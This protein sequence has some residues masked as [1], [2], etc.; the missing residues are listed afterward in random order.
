MNI[1]FREEQIEILKYEKGIMSISAVPGSGKTFILTHLAAKLIK[2]NIKEGEK[3]LLLTYMNSAVEN[4]ESRL[5]ELIDIDML[6]KIQISTI[7]KLAAD[8]LKE[9]I[10][11][12]K[13]AENY[14]LVDIYD[15]DRI[16][17]KH[18]RVW[19]NLEKNKFKFLFKDKEFNERNT[20]DFYNVLKKSI[21]FNISKLKMEGITYHKIFTETDKYDNSLLPILSKIYKEYQ[22]E[23]NKKSAIDYD[24]L[25]FYTYDLL[26]NNK[27]I[28]DIYIKRYK[29]IFEDEAQDSNGLQNKIIALLSGKLGNIVKV[30]DSNQSIMG[31][32]TS[33]SPDIFRKFVK[34]APIKKEVSLSARNTIDIQKLANL[35]HKYTKE[36]HPCIEARGALVKPYIFPVEEGLYKNP[37]ADG[38]SIKQITL[39]DEFEETKYLIYFIKKFR[40]KYPEKSIGILLPRNSLISTISAKLKKE[41]IEFDTISDIDLEVMEALKKLGDIISFLAE[42]YNNKE[43]INIIK[44]YFL[45][46]DE[47]INK[48]IIRALE[49]IWLEKL[50]FTDYDFEEKVKNSSQFVYIKKAINKLSMLLE[51]SINSP[52]RI[53]VYIGEN[54]G[55]SVEDQSLIDAIALNLKKVFKLNPKWTLKDLAIE[56]K[57]SQNN[58]FS[59]FNPIIRDKKEKEKNIVITNYH[60]SKGREWD[61]V[62]LYGLNTFYFPVFL[63]QAAYGDK[64]YLHEKHLNPEAYMSWEIDNYLGKA[65]DFDPILKY[66]SDRVAECIRLIFVGITRAK[67]HIL[68][69]H[70]RE[71]DDF[72]S[73]LFKKIIERIYNG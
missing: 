49:N 23:L 67:E 38:R 55:F 9:N 57:K 30:G 16:I 32:F 4:F 53:L 28:C 70:N 12:T 29:Y 66:K 52:E 65:V 13:L 3:L 45:P 40:E 19:F 64:R 7:H 39:E 24:D 31:T 47:Y 58:K 44:N 60:K 20:K 27:E 36:K 34:G 6:N 41:G 42:P 8:I 61:M 37:V 51:F 17:D 72:Y 10:S 59:R 68:L 21:S 54:F 71:K 63:S 14:T 22:E 18:L 62:Y 2:E 73:P 25:L 69:S 26:K 50:F 56:L 43:F 5:K 48:D 11:Y 1:E 33:A 35:F 15:K 46:K